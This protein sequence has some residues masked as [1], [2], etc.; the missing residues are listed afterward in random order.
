[1]KEYKAFFDEYKET[2][3]FPEMP[4][5]VNNLPVVKEENQNTGGGAQAQRPQVASAEGNEKDKNQTGEQKP[6]EAPAE[7]DKKVEEKKE[8]EKK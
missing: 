5:I 6:S 3:A 2:K 8:E 7:G 1:M 4:V